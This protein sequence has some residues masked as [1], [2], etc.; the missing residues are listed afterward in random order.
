M[1]SM[2]VLTTSKSLLPRFYR[3]IRLY[4]LLLN[5]CSPFL[6]LP[7]SPH[8]HPSQSNSNHTS[9]DSHRKVICPLSCC[10]HIYLHFKCSSFFFRN[11]TCSIL[12]CNLPVSFPVHKLIRVYIH[13]Y[14]LA[15]P[16]QQYRFLF[17]PINLNIQFCKQKIIRKLYFQ[18]SSPAS[19]LIN[20]LSFQNLRLLI[21]NPTNLKSL[22]SSCV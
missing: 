20:S 5:R 6:F 17:L 7:V 10:F 18:Q 16:I 2:T 15:F 12:C 8:S 4:S 22:R 13:C 1:E 9:Y 3:H 11:Q 14:I 21:I 19:N